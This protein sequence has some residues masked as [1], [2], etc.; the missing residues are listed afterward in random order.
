MRIFGT[1][2]ALL[3]FALVACGDDGGEAPPGPIILGPADG[4]ELMA[5]DTGRV[6]VGNT[7]PDFSLPTFRGDTVTLSEF[8][9]KREVILVFYRG[10]W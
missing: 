10:S 1:P 3:A 9:G 8:E 2:I 7:A 6:R 4:L 5:V